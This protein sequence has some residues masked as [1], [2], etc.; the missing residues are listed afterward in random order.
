M[1]PNSLRFGVFLVPLA[2]CYAEG[3]AASP[4][5]VCYSVT[6]PCTGS[7]IRLDESLVAVEDTGP[8]IATLGSDYVASNFG[9]NAMVLHES[10]ESGVALFVDR[11]LIEGGVGNGLMSVAWRVDGT[12][13][14][15]GQG[16][17]ESFFEIGAGYDGSL[18]SPHIVVLDSFNPVPCCDVRTVDQSGTFA[19]PFEYGVPFVFDFE[20]VGFVGSGG[21]LAS[22]P[23]SARIT[24][25]GLPVGASLDAASDTVY[26]ALT[27]VP[28]P[29]TLL[30]VGSGV[31]SLGTQRW[32]RRRRRN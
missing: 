10:G 24:G 23:G 32:W 20:L 12:V 29:M 26:P 18:T 9:N 3:A 6:A 8:S 17:S 5:T 4:L 27:T 1:I 28:E 21:G 7:V 2:F 16:P 15:A 13:Q 31:V 19:V 25:I 22:F 11:F 14:T 30:L